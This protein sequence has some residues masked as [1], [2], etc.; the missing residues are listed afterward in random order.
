MGEAQKIVGFISAPDWF[1]PAP[2]EF[3]LITKGGVGV[4]QTF[5]DPPGFDYRTENIARCE[6]ALTHAARHLAGVGCS[7]IASPATP[8][9]FLGHRNIAGARAQLGRIEAAC[10]TPCI[11]SITAMMDTLEDWQ[12]R[13]VALACTY[14][15]DDW[16]DLWSA[17]VAASGFEVLSA[18][19]LVNQ[20][21][22]APPDADVVEYPTPDE[23]GRGIAKM[24]AE[25]PEA[26]VIVVTG[27]GARTLAIT[28]TLREVSGKRILAADTAL[29]RSISARLGIDL[30][31]PL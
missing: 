10:G 2:D 13:K 18:A 5:F 22:K 6:P 4:Q 3:R 21:I 20:G 12:V 24:A 15:P 26:E 19:S 8:F 9:G 31:L 23:I 7:V 30:T 1:D 27:S 17:F 29:Y 11:T 28:R 25:C 14:Y 16:R